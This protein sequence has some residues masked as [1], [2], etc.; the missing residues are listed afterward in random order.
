[1]LKRNRSKPIAEIADECIGINRRTYAPVEV[2]RDRKG[3]TLYVPILPNAKLNI[4]FGAETR[5]M[6]ASD[7]EDARAKPIEDELIEVEYPRVQRQ[8]PST[9]PDIKVNVDI[10][11]IQPKLRDNRMDK[12]T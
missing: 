3:R 11:I 7:S 5:S 9:I 2:N 6:T 4:S 12:K 1:M 8:Q 10:E